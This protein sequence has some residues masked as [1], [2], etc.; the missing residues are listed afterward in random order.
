MIVVSDTSPLVSLSA[1][2]RLDLLRALFGRVLIPEA[3]YREIVEQGAGRPGASEVAVASW[4][5]RQTPTDAALASL[6]K[7]E[8]DE[9]EAEAITLALESAADVVLLDERRGRQRAEALGL[10]VTGVLGILVEAKR[11]GRLGEIR[12]AL[13]ALRETAGFWLSNHLYRRALEMAGEL[14]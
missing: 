8:L 12:P 3:V 9:G 13:D 5:E 10:R 11:Q 14:P 7:T 2:G 4:I 1:V 6:L